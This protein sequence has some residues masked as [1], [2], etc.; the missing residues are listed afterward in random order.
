MTRR[1]TNPTGFK[2]TFK[3][4]KKKG[5]FAEDLVKTI[6]GKKSKPIFN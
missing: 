6:K 5:S 4:G 2:L 1:K 3:K